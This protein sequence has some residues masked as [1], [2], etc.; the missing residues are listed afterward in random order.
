MVRR[1]PDSYRVAR[2][3]FRFAIL[4][5]L[6]LTWVAY[7]PAVEAAGLLGRQETDFIVVGG[8]VGL[9][10]VVAELGGWKGWRCP[11]CTNRLRLQPVE[12]PSTQCTLLVR[13]SRCGEGWDSGEPFV[14]QTDN[15]G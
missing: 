14:S 8:W 15:G 13:C 4:Y 3:R 11:D 7:L 1:L 9:A 2:R 6:V 5:P 12:Y 10:L